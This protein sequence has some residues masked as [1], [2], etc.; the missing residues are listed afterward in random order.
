[1][2]IYTSQRYQLRSDDNQNKKDPTQKTNRIQPHNRK[3][4][5]KKLPVTLILGTQKQKR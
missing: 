3:Q 2:K 4:C 5:Q 1:M